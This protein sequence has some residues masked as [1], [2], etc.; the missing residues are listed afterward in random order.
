M[1]IDYNRRCWY[2]YYTAD[3]LTQAGMI[4]AVQEAA[5]C[6]GFFHLPPLAF[7]PDRKAV[8]LLRPAA[9]HLLSLILNPS[10]RWE[11]G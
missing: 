5:D 10:G 4:Q 6:D 2:L 11:D 3:F 1:G 7:S 8:T 9:S